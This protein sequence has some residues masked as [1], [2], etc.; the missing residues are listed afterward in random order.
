M[1]DN[2]LEKIDQFKSCLFEYNASTNIYSKKSYDTLDYHIEDSLNLAK[3]IKPS[4]VHVDMGSGSGLPGV[5]IAIASSAK[6]ICIESKSKKRLFL[7]YV[8]EALDLN[9]LE[10]FDGDVQLFANRYSGPKIESLSAK[11]FVKPPKLLMYLSMFRK[12]QFRRQTICWVP[13]SYA[14]SEILERFG[15]VVSIST[16]DS[17]FL[18]FKIQMESYQSYKADL[19]TQYNL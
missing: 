7:S 13:I 10:I 4:S 16:Q 9:N 2:I 15:E 11:A 19:K 6:V 1:L 17:T 14:Q 8:K 3:L 12:H 18:Y 5:I